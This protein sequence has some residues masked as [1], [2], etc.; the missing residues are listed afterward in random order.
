MPTHGCAID[1]VKMKYKTK[2]MIDSKNLLKF[3]FQEKWS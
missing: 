1:K 2:N 3:D